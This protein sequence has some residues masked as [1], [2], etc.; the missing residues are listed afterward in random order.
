MNPP[1]NSKK[2][3]GWLA[4]RELRKWFNTEESGQPRMLYF[5]VEQSKLTMSDAM[6][7]AGAKR[8]DFIVIDPIPEPRLHHFMVDSKYQGT[9]E[10]ILSASDMRKSLE[11][12]RL[13]KMPLYLALYHAV[14]NIT[15]NAEWYWVPLRA[16]FEEWPY[17]PRCGDS[18]FRITPDASYK[19]RYRVTDL[20][21]VQ[22]LKLLPFKVMHGQ[23]PTF[24]SMPM[25]PAGANYRNALAHYVGF[26][27][28][29]VPRNASKKLGWA[30]RSMLF[31]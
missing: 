13:H 8:Q 26:D 31:P 28:V 30:V 1:R 6:R 4:E 25:Q 27:V 22:V 14:D 19:A 24:K 9:P 16:V 5:P 20:A 23:F 12:E 3:K 17:D 29:Q 7:K 10:W 21:S 15:T 2:Y 11:A 18:K